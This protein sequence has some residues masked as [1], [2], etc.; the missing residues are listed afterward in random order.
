MTAPS[1]V[2][3]A[4]IRVAALPSSRKRRNGLIPRSQ[5]LGPM[6]IGAPDHAVIALVSALLSTDLTMALNQCE[7]AVEGA[8]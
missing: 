6:H 3:G 2:G 1:R 4:V 5:T 7:G 8:A